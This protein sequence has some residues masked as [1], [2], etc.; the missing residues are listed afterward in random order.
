MNLS[1]LGLQI[2]SKYLDFKDVEKLLKL[3]SDLK[4]YYH[5]TFNLIM[6]CALM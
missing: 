2:I 4:Y 6:F 3:N 5:T 1:N